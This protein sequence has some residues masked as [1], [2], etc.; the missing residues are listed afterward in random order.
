LLNKKARAVQLLI[1]NSASSSYGQDWMI[2]GIIL[3]AAS[4]FF[5]QKTRDRVRERQSLPSNVQIS[6]VAASS[7]QQAFLAQKP[8]MDYAPFV[9]PSR[10]KVQERRACVLQFEKEL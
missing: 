4:D 5:A 8:G 6:G 1:Q 9:A 7:I 3:V 10:L 2:I